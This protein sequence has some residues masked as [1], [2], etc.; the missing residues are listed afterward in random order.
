[1]A[2]DYA[3]QETVAHHKSQLCIPQH[4]A[5]RCHCLAALAFPFPPGASS[6]GYGC[7]FLSHHT[8]VSLKDPGLASSSQVPMAVVLLQDRC[9]SNA[10]LTSTGA[11]LL[12]S[13]RII[14]LIL[15]PRIMCQTTSAHV[16]DVSWMDRA[17]PSHRCPASRSHALRNVST[18]PQL[19]FLDLECPSHEFKRQPRETSLRGH[20]HR[21]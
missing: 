11:C 14:F 1:M 19:P 5:G 16:D 21:A 9:S 2:S 18:D 10:R 3:G 15:F 7:V 13:I 20:A 8:T 12:I 17:F 6:N 4:P